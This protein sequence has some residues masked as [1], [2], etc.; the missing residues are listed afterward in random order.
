MGLAAVLLAAVSIWGC[1][2]APSRIPR[3]N[4]EPDRDDSGFK[5]GVE[6]YLTESN[7]VPV[8]LDWS[9]FDAV[10]ENP[11]QQVIDSMGRVFS[12]V[13]QKLSNVRRSTHANQVYLLY[14]PFF[15]AGCRLLHY[16]RL[17][18]S[19]LSVEDKQALEAQARELLNRDATTNARRR[20]EMQ[21]L[22]SE[23]CDWLEAG[24]P[25]KGIC[26][27]RVLEWFEAQLIAAASMKR[28]RDGE[29]SLPLVSVPHNIV[30]SLRRN[31]QVTD[32]RV[33]EAAEKY[34]LFHR[35][36]LEPPR[37]SLTERDKVATDALWAAVQIVPDHLSRASEANIQHVD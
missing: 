15:M 36:L 22:L 24:N 35:L 16:S 33:P 20:N 11:D 5:T 29:L 4:K 32:P 14:L 28:S 9:H 25:E 1:G 31:P 18:S 7:K 21:P 6:A 12:E 34:V 19:P 17:E 8:H 2:D 37:T 13:K 30:I 10:M 26:V 27:R 3:A 23:L